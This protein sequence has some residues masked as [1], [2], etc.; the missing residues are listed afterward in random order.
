MLLRLQDAVDS[1]VN[2]GDFLLGLVVG[3]LVLIGEVA[4]YELVDLAVGVALR[5][6]VFDHI[7]G[8]PGHPGVL[9]PLVRLRWQERL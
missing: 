6:Q 2:I 4:I 9:L 3:L 7:V 1:L 8:V 5:Q